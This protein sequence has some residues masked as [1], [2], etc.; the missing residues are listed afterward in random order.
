[1]RSSSVRRSRARA[2]GR[3]TSF[4]YEAA[5]GVVYDRACDQIRPKTEK[6]RAVYNAQIVDG[7]LGELAQPARQFQ[8][9]RLGARRA[10][11]SGVELIHS[12]LTSPISPL[13]PP[14]Y[15]DSPAIFAER[16]GQTPVTT[17]HRLQSSSSSEAYEELVHVRAG[18]Q[19]RLDSRETAPERMVDLGET[20]IPKSL[21]GMQE[22][23]TT[24][25]RFVYGSDLAQHQ[26]GGGR[27]RGFVTELVWI[28]IHPL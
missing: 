18:A 21:R 19:Q 11:R 15:S 25:T 22:T 13:D 4:G 3:G 1:V 7:T 16:V 2:S 8:L 28:Y 24:T 12:R 10:K 26:H 20:R 6:I 14:G 17:E 23:L 27:V 9:G 5:V